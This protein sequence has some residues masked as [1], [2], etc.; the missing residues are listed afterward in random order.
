MRREQAELKFALC[1]RNDDCD[2]L[3][4][5]KLYRV[6]PDQRAAKE[7]YLRIVDESGEDYLHPASYF[8]AVRLPQ[9]PGL[10]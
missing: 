1:V 5:R 6:L 4:I 3:E 9:K 10:R 7:D 2:D 8:V